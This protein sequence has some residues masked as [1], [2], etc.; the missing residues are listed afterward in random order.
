M[1]DEQL[2]RL[3]RSLRDAG[4]RTALPEEDLASIRETAREEWQRRYVR[5]PSR[6]TARRWIPLAAAAVI[7][8]AVGIVWRA[9]T[10]EPARV[11]APIVATVERA[12]EAAPWKVGSALPAEAEIET[13]RSGR[14]ALRMAG[15]ASARL[16][17]GT[18]VRLASSTL[19]ELT[20]GAVYVDTRGGDPVSV[21]ASA[22]LCQPSGTQF[23]VRVQDD[24][25]LLKVREGTVRFER[26]PETVHAAAG[27]HLAVREDGGLVRRSIPPFGPEWEW[28]LAAAPMP[29]IE[30]MKVRRFLDW[31]GR[32]T[33]WRVEF[34]DRDVSTLADS[35]DLHGSISHLTPAEAVGVVL[36][37]AGLEYRVSD[38][39]LVVAVSRKG[40]P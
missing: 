11:A 9:R 37:S 24:A 10:K 38:G 1:S 22:G 5:R 18:Q 26:G 36:S 40:R 35:V 14:L 28:V 29:D 39:T 6:K 7:T 12:A 4:P 17:A 19:I 25:T 23:E 15:G 20:R 32:E 8:L 30:G 21:R 31:I 2:E 33:G 27:E 34:A 13:D 16:D 3:E